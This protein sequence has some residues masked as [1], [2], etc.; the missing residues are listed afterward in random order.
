M[1]DKDPTILSFF[2]FTHTV[3]YNFPTRLWPCYKKLT[4]RSALKPVVPAKSI[5]EMPSH[6][7]V[8]GKH[9]QKGQTSLRCTEFQ[10]TA[11]INQVI[12]W[13]V[14]IITWWLTTCSVCRWLMSDADLFKED[15][16]DWLVASVWYWFILR[17]KCH[18][19]RAWIKPMR[20]ASSEYSATQTFGREKPKSATQT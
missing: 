9:R 13:P 17:E 19:N 5:G 20:W 11:E 10:L 8:S 12:N 1:K 15:N 3:C 16:A 18:M 6:R 2:F 7:L 4:Y 14:I